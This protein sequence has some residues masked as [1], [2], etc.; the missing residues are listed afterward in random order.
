[1]EDAVSFTEHHQ[2]LVTFI[3]RH[4]A[5]F[6]AARNLVM[7]AASSSLALAAYASEDVASLTDRSQASAI[8]IADHPALF[9][10]LLLS[11]IGCRRRV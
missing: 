11:G 8:L 3:D 10:A 1:M 6:A 2:L 5:R 7:K 4:L 9:T